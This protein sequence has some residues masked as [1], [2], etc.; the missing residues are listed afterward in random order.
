MGGGGKSKKAASALD[1][2]T[3]R[4]QSMLRSRGE[5]YAFEGVQSFASL[6]NAQTHI[7]GGKKG[8]LCCEV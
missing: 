1:E 5:T 2:T 6:Q 4:K 7:R 8:M 3:I